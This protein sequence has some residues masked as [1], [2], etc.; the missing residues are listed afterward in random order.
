M[1]TNLF[2]MTLQAA[3]STET[4]VPSVSNTYTKAKIVSPMPVLEQMQVKGWDSLE[5]LF[6]VEQNKHSDDTSVNCLVKLLIAQIYTSPV[7]VTAFTNLTLLSFDCCHKLRYLF[8]YSIAKLLVKLQEI[9]M[10]NCKVVKQ[11]VQREGEDSLTLSLPQSNSLK[12]HENSSSSHHATLS[13]EASA[14]H[15]P[16]SLK[17]INISHCGVLEIVIGEAE[18]KIDT[19]VSFAQLQSLTLS[20]LPNVVSFC[21]TPCASEPPSF[22]N[23]H[24]SGYQTHE[25]HNP[26]LSSDKYC[27]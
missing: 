4:V 25:V 18:E 19:I 15:W 1:I 11:L 17:R 24:G 22:E 10:S 6:L 14:L 2:L 23:C 3:S 13:R 16:S 26:L 12:L 5:V 27:Y 20:H 7:E 21:L 9:K 8:P